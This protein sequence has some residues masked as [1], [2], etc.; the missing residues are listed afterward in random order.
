MPALNEAQRKVAKAHRMLN[1]GQKRK[2]KEIAD[3]GYQLSCQDCRDIAA[4]WADADFRK[5]VKRELPDFW[6]RMTA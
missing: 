1:P 4:R 2:L 3:V 5:E 6:E